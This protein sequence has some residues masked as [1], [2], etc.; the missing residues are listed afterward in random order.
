MYQVLWLESYHSVFLLSV[1]NSTF[2]LDTWKTVLSIWEQTQ[3]G[4]KSSRLSKRHNSIHI[5]LTCQDSQSTALNSSSCRKT[6]ACR[7]SIPETFTALGKEWK[8]NASSIQ[9]DAAISCCITNVPQQATQPSWSASKFVR[10]RCQKSGIESCETKQTLLIWSLFV[11]HS[12]LRLLMRSEL[13]CHSCGFNAWGAP[14]VNSLHLV[15]E[16]GYCS[17]QFLTV[18]FLFNSILCFDNSLSRHQAQ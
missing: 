14:A 8:I 12:K 9:G 18:C 7:A 6:A 16:L 2:A 5:N 3:G 1:I 17:N 15:L 4:K 13:L 11:W 10:Q